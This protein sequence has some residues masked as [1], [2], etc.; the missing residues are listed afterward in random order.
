MSDSTDSVSLTPERVARWLGYGGLLPFAAAA[1]LVAM[2]SAGEWHTLAS[3]VLLAYGAVILS[4]LGGI[5]WGLTLRNETLAPGLAAREFVYSVCP[6]LLGWVALL[7]PLRSGAGLLA[8]CVCAAFVHDALLARQHE[9]P[10]WFL[11]L[12]LQLSLGAVTALSL[13]AVYGPR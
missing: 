9:L 6:S 13:A 5:V 10:R 1:A 11:S 12:R 3:R 2:L 8:A 7:M 4:F